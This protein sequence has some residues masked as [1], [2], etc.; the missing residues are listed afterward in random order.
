MNL[1]IQKVL[2]VTV[3][4]S[5]P[6]FTPRIPII[7]HNSRTW[8]FDRVV[9]TGVLRPLRDVSY[10]RFTSSDYEMSTIIDSHSNNVLP[11]ANSSGYRS[12]RAMGS[13]EMKLI[14]AR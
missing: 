9:G 5:Y 6:Q 1:G 2:P 7:G 13:D 10:T 12:V 8:N 14:R 4:S 11:N 3:D